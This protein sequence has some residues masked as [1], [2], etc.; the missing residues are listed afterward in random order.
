MLP[1]VGFTCGEGTC[2]APAVETFYHQRN[3]DQKMMKRQF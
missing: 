3:S 1:P 2:A